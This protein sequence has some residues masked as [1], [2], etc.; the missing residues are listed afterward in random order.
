MATSNRDGGGR[1]LEVLAAVLAPFVDARMSGVA[2]AGRDWVEVL[3]ARHSANLGQEVKYSGS[4][5]RLLLR[6]ITEE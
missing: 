3:A 5:P 2:P 4:D 1:G 6:V